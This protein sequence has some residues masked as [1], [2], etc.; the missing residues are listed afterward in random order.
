MDNRYNYEDSFL[1]KEE[2]RKRAYNEVMEKYNKNQKRALMI[3]FPILGAIYFIL[4]IILFFVDE[5][6]KIPGIVFV[7][8]GVFFL[9]LCLVLK[10]AFKNKQYTSEE[11]ENKL[12]KNNYTSYLVQEVRIKLLEDEVKELKSKIEELERKIK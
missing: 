4:G 7:C 6:T 2:K 3:V 10:N 8:L 11:I 12:M 9:L 1:T 5:E